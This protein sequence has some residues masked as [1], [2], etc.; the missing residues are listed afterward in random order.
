MED[1]AIDYFTPREEKNIDRFIDT[2]YKM[3]AMFGGET[4]IQEALDNL[5][6]LKAGV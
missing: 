3:K 1:Q 5:N 4:T 6:T 2:L